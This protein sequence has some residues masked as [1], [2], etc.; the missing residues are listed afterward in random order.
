[1]NEAVDEQ[2]TRSLVP[3]LFP[4]P[5]SQNPRR[6]SVCVFLSLSETAQSAPHSCTCYHAPGTGGY[7]GGDRFIL[8]DKDADTDWTA[9]S[10]GPLE[11][12]IYYV[13]NWRGDVVNLL[14]DAGTQIESVRYSA[15]GV[16][17]AM[18]AGDNDFNGDVDST[19]TDQI[20]TWING[21]AYAVCGDLNLDGDVD[22]TDKVTAASNDAVLASALAIGPNA[23]RC[24]RGNPTLS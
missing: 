21:A 12:R 18:P 13:Q 22:A 19:D 11:E 1:M 10:D 20:Q 2:V 9:S 14:T 8:R 3:D 4:G 15:Y 5:T 7:V 16:P 17:F 24:S 23:C 6:Q